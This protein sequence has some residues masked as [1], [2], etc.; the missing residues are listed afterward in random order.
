MLFT[1]FMSIV[2]YVFYY[3]CSIYIGHGITTSPKLPSNRL[4]CFL[5]CP[6]WFPVG[7]ACSPPSSATW[8]S[9][10]PGAAS[11]GTEPNWKTAEG[12]ERHQGAIDDVLTP[13]RVW[14]I[15]KGI[16]FENRMGHV[17]SFSRFWGFDNGRMKMIRFCSF[18]DT[19]LSEHRTATEDILQQKWKGTKIGWSIPRLSWKLRI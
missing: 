11:I 18:S 12:L 19:T 13:R 4:P 7:V 16:W 6:G 14:A 10:L 5:H 1:M 17:D 8:S 3:F 2:Y 15:F 9:P